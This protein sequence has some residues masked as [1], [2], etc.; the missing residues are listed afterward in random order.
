[1]TGRPSTFQRVVRRDIDGVF[2]N[3]AEFAETVE[4]DG[5]PVIVIVLD[6]SGTSLKA[7]G[8]DDLVNAG[9]SAVTLRLAFKTGD[10]PQ[11][12][13]GDV[14]NVAGFLMDVAEWVTE[15]GMDVVSLSRTEPTVGG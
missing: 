11:R 2:L 12:Q 13:P 5:R 6:D 14:L 9:L 10:V 8:S 3:A 7:F 1:M 4:V 15:S